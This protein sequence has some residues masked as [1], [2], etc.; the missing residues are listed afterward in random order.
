MVINKILSAPSLR[1]WIVGLFFLVGVFC[2]VQTR[3]SAINDF[4][5]YYYGSKLL[6]EGKF[7]QRV[8]SDLHHF[9]EHIRAYGETNFFENYSPVPPFSAIFYIP[10]CLLSSNQAK[11]LFNLFSL[12]VFCLALWRLIARFQAIHPAMLLLPLVLF[13]PLYSSLHQGQSYLLIAALFLEIYVQTEKGKL[14]LPSFF[15]ALIVALKIFPVVMLVYFFLTRNYKVLVYT[16]LFW[17]G[18]LI[19]SYAVLPNETLFYYSEILPRLSQNDVVGAY[20]PG[21]QSAF[22]LL[23]NLFSADAMHNP[24]PVLHAPFL[25]SLLES[26]L[27]ALLLV[28]LWQSRRANSLKLFALCFLAANLLSRYTTSYSILLL[29][30]LV[31]WILN[32]E[33]GYWRIGLLL[34][35]V[36]ATNIPINTRSSFFALQYLR[37]FGLLAMFVMCIVHY[38]PRIDLKLVLAVLL[39][40][41][42]LRYL[43]LPVNTAR[44]FEIQNQH[45]ILY[46]LAFKGD[47]IHLLSTQGHDDV[48]ETYYLPGK[49]DSSG[50]SVKQTTI[51]YKGRALV[52]TSDSKKRPFVHNDSVLVF[53]SD[54]NQGYG[55][56]KLRQIPFVVGR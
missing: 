35:F 55:F 50:L 39:P 21:N 30:P 20:F 28:F 5:N 32:E 23:L 12:V 54:L 3:H 9:N 37:L 51:L 18:L 7:D 25:V 14:V 41:F 46:D 10:F 33:G 48:V 17:L 29:V 43:S 45:G 11:L 34:V 38:C 27:N 44:Y 36:V 4:G 26:L 2:L 6:V 16:C 52:E 8:Y 22:T 19:M 15:L 49:K 40:I 47:S 42:A 31:I 24:D 13:F 1:R 56:Y 53:M